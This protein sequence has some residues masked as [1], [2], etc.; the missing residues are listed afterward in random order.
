M[1]SKTMKEA[2]IEVLLVDDHAVVREG[3]R[4]L[5]EA[6]GYIRVSG[7]AGDGATAYRLFCDQAFDVVVMDITLPGVSGLDVLRRMRART[8]DARILMFSMHEDEVFPARA[9]RL[10]AMGYV[11]KSSAPEVLV[12]AV[13][14]V[15]QGR[16]FLSSD[17][18]PALARPENIPGSELNSREFEIL[19]LLVHGRSLGE[20][21][22]ML[23]LSPKTV[24]NYQTSLRE[25]FGV[26]NDFQMMRIALARGM[27]ALPGD[28]TVVGE[29]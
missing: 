16:L 17:I 3:Y 12:E 18:A 11:S 9:M 5:L 26:S 24:S 28:T 22:E 6:T 19:R 1:M 10:G 23:H 13:R 2:T 25:K 20:I 4:R 8:P 15:A 29:S 7:E 14:V 21:A 27:A